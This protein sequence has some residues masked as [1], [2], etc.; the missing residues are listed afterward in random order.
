M[1]GKYKNL[2]IVHSSRLD[3]SAGLQQM[4]DP[5]KLGSK[6]MREWL[7]PQGEGKQ[8]KRKAPPSVSLYDLPTEGVARVKRMT[9]HL[10]TQITG[11][12]S[13]SG[14]WL[15]PDIVKFTTKSRHRRV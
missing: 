12:P 11:A 8:A 6:A 14:W 3:V 7:C 9:S 4:L 2:V 10:K 1:T 5:N 13:I 15:I